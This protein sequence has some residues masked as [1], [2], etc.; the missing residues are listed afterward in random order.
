MIDQLEIWR[1]RSWVWWLP[2]LF[3]VVNIGSILFFQTTFAGQLDKLENNY[4][5][6]A[7]QLGEYK[8]EVERIDQFLDQV[9]DQERMVSSLYRDHFGTESE[10]FTRVLREIRTLARRAGLDPKS[11]SYP[12][13]EIG[14]YELNR[15]GIR[16][17][18][19]GTYDQLRTFIN[20]LE[21]TD[22]FLTLESITLAGGKGDRDARLQIRFNVSTMFAHNDASSLML[23]EEVELTEDRDL[24][25]DSLDDGGSDQEADL[26]N[27]AIGLD[28]EASERVEEMQG[29]ELDPPASQTTLDQDETL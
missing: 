20:F 11:F 6:Q 14:E 1:R 19:D 26:E 7:E 10:R 18:V 2:L 22:Q 4:D 3:V 5:K 9:K 25:E 15:L 24:P 12:G 21:L 16:F 28:E 13:G 29:E 23:P 27:G 8:E 17:S